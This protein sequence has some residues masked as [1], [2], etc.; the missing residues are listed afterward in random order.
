MANRRMI[1]IQLVG[2]LGLIKVCTITLGRFSSASEAERFYQVM[3]EGDT[4]K[5]DRI[6]EELI[7]FF[8]AYL[9]FCVQKEEQQEPL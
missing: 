5:T 4:D 8:N 6:K 1:S 2:Y 3:R 7:K 9:V